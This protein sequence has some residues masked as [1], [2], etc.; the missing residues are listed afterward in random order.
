MLHP[1]CSGPLRAIII[2]TLDNERE[3]KYVGGNI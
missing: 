3:P 1:T 2:C